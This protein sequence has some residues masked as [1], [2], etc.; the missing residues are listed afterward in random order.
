MKKE[1]LYLSTAIIM[2]ACSASRKVNTDTPAFAANPV[3]AHRGAWKTKQLPENSI[4]ALREAIALKCTGSEFDI[5]RSADD[6]LVI[7]HDATFFK[8]PIEKTNYDVLTQHT[9][10]NGEKLPTLREYLLAG[11]KNNSSTRLILEIKPSTVSKDRGQETGA[12][13]VKL[14]QELKAE[15]MVAYISFDYDICKKIIQLDPK[16]HVQ[17]LE[18]NQPPAQVKADRLGGI[19]YHYSAFQKHPEWIREAKEQKLVL[20]AWTVNDTATMDFLLKNGF[21]LITTNEPE[22]LMQRFNALKK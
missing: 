8:L 5:H 13:V 17:Y 12:Q 4:A 19:D 7:N 10:S 18:A 6:S 2:T 14:V 16:A 22:L 11:L 15:P 21:D 3:V 20:N 9:L 1:F